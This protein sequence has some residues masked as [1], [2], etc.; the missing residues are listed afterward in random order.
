MIIL[1]LNFLIAHI[2]ETYEMVI[3]DKIIHKY[4]DKAS[5][6]KEY[7]EI[8]QR[9]DWINAP[10]AYMIFTISSDIIL[11]EDSEDWQGFVDSI[12]KHINK[13]NEGLRE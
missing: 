7:Y 6:N 13:K 5:L 8:I 11:E 1:L 10:I 12:K 2:S 9:L 3:A 4:H